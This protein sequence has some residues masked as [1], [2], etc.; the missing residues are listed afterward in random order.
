[1]EALIRHVPNSATTA[2]SIDDAA[3]RGDSRPHFD[4]G[5]IRGAPHGV[6]IDIKVF[7]DV[8]LVEVLSK[9]AD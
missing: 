1:M 8:N 3:V 5:R 9:T 4:P 6:V 2:A 7:N